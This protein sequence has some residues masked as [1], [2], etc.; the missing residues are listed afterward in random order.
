MNTVHKATLPAYP[1]DKKDPDDRVLATHRDLDSVIDDD[2]LNDV[3]AEQQMI[4]GTGDTQ[5][6]FQRMERTRSLEQD[7]P[8]SELD[9]LDP[10]PPK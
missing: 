4:E 3:R 8:D 7:E 9:S 10:V 2:E 6:T 5:D 1:E